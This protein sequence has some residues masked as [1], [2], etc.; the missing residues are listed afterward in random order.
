MDIIQN[1]NAEPGLVYGQMLV[2]SE[3]LET[4]FDWSRRMLWYTKKT[5]MKTLPEGQIFNQLLQINFIPLLTAIFKR[6]LYDKIGGI[7]EHMEIA[8]DYDLFVKLAYIT[9]VRAVQ[10][11][12][13]LYRV[14]DCN[15]S[16]H[17]KEQGHLETLEIVS[18][19]LPSRNAERALKVHHTIR[20]IQEVRNQDIFQGLR[21]FIKYGG[22]GSLFFVIF[23]RI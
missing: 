19:Y 1:D 17:K 10:A 11:V 20:A 16:N 3:D 18:R 21:R 14:H 7:S 5:M 8:E 22:V 15:I 23:V 4:K 13:A 9:K 12:V 2:Q 6:D